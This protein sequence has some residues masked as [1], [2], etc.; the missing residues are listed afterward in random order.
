MLPSVLLLFDFKTGASDAAPAAEGVSG[1]Q[2][3]VGRRTYFAFRCVLVA[4]LAGLLTRG[5]P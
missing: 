2:Y 4:A 1:N 3:M 5:G